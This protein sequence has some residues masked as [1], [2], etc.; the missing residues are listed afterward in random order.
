MIK[1][2]NAGDA[3][4]RLMIIISMVVKMNLTFKNNP[5]DTAILKL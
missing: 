5:E 1:E 2:K 4:I 3:S